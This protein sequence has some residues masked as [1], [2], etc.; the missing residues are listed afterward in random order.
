MLTAVISDIHGNID[1]LEA[2]LADIKTQGADRI[3]C[4]GD[5]VGYGPRPNECVQLVEDNCVVRILGNHDQ[6]AVSGIVP[7]TW[8]PYAR[9]AMQ[10]TQRVLNQKA[11]DSIA[12]FQTQAELDGVMLVHGSPSD[13]TH[14]Y[15]TSYDWPYQKAYLLN[16][17]PKQV[18]L[19]GHTHKPGIF[20]DTNVDSYRTFKQE[21][22]AFGKMILNV[23]SVGQP[24]DY[25]SKSCYLLYDDTHFWWRR[26]QYDIDSCVKKMNHEGIDPLLSERLKVG[27]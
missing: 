23:G 13:P 8:N 1:A 10:W 11:K 24:R 12:K 21:F 5:V 2:V 16:D 22:A 18:A 3:V 25:D 19:C 14:E 17:I 7:S 27:R 20:S 26:V 4:L 6:A 9:A 15:V